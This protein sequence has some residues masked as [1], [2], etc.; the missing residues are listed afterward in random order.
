[1]RPLVCQ[2]YLTTHSTTVFRLAW[3]GARPTSARDR[4]FLGQQRVL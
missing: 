4:R 1:M 3:Y 2:F